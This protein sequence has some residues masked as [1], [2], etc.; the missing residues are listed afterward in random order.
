M[1]LFERINNKIKNNLIIEMN[2]TGSDDPWDNKDTKTKNNKKPNQNKKINKNVTSSARVQATGDIIK[3]GSKSTPSQKKT[4]ADVLNSVLG[5]T[6]DGNRFFTD[7]SDSDTLKTKPSGDEGSFRR[8]ANKNVVNREIKK[9]I[10]GKTK[11]ISV[12]ALD[13]RDAS[14]KKLDKVVIKPQQG[15]AKK[16]EKL[17]SKIEKNITK[18]KE[19]EVK[20]AEK[21]VKKFVKQSEASKRA[22]EFTDNINQKNKNYRSARKSNL[23]KKPLNVRMKEFQK[24][25]KKIDAANPVEVGKTGQP[26]PV[27]GT[28]LKVSEPG[29]V[30]GSTKQ[31]GMQ[32]GTPQG[33][34]RIKKTSKKSADGLNPEAKKIMSKQVSSDE[35]L[36]NKKKIEKKIVNNTKNTTKPSLWSRTKSKLKDIHNWM[37]SDYRRTSGKGIAKNITRNTYKNTLRGNTIRNINKVLPGK[38]KVLAAIA[39]GAYLYS[40]GNK[41]DP[42]AAGAGAG[43]KKYYGANPKLKLDMKGSPPPPKAK[44]SKK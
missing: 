16:T 26:V 37:K 27:K 1:S 31:S 30:T 40:R 23:S 19:G 20:K 4:A 8:N 7:K 41:K 36:G 5:K 44:E 11:N 14:I 6:K 32:Q 3:S 13:K 18:P 39:T 2:N 29:K 28:V 10:P 35:L 15:D 33:F 42:G 12:S 25:Q 38:Y 21:V 17:I 34:E 9:T 22:K 43:P 24:I